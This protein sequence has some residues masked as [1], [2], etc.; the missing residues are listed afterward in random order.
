MK[1]PLPTKPGPRGGVGVLHKTLDIIETLRHDQSGSGLAD[2]SRHVDMP[3][4][5]VYRILATLEGR[6]YLDRGGDGSY[7]L[8]R[9]F[10]DLK[11][12][13][14]IDERVSKA[15]R[16]PMLKLMESSRETVNLGTLD[17]GEVVVISTAE[18][19]QAV[20][21]V[22]KVGNRRCLHT[23]ALG[24]VMLAEMTEVEALRLLKVKGMPRLTPHSLVTKTALLAELRRIRQQGY[25]VDDQENEM[26]GRC[27]GAPIRD[28]DGLAIAAL[29]VSA[30]VPH[31]SRPPREHSLPTP[32][33]LRNDYA[34]H[35]AAPGMQATRDLSRV[36]TG[37]RR[38]RLKSRA[39]GSTAG[40]QR[41][42]SCPLFDFFPNPN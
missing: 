40:S 33:D 10:F 4:A 5:T 14:S 7:R 38:T 19:P 1:N 8:A 21:M 3:K 37:K 23:T 29:S 17:A 16:E 34:R 26:E 13:A 11:R 20:R 9:K 28:S 12:D 31:G 41:N 24:K 2:L 32:G 39:P 18:S 22:S 25:A 15:A 35:R 30:R 27:V 36:L 6:G 42:R